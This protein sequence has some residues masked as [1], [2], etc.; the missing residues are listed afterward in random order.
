MLRFVSPGNPRPCWEGTKNLR[1]QSVRKWSGGVIRGGGGWRVEGKKKRGR[2][3]VRPRCG[4][5]PGL[6]A[7]G[8]LLVFDHQFAVFDRHADKRDGGGDGEE[9]AVAVGRY[10]GGDGL[11]GG[12]VHDAGELGAAKSGGRSGGDRGARDRDVGHRGVV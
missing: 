1:H 12:V 2:T 4:N 3:L 10:V 9:A 11:G 8:R 6:R 5:G 7:G